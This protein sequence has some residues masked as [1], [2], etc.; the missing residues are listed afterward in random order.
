L[1]AFLSAFYLFEN[2][3]QRKANANAYRK[4]SEPVKNIIDVVRE[5][6]KKT[7]PTLTAIAATYTTKTGKSIEKEELFR[8]ISETEKTGIM[9]SYIA[10]K[11]DEPTQAWKAQMFS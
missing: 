3:K 6:Q 10:S 8:R 7:T 9:R 1:L 5:T 11:Q 4:L 2:L